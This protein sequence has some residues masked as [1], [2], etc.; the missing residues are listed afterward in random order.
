MSKEEGKDDEGKKG[1]AEKKEGGGEKKKD[2]KGNGMVTVTICAGGG[3]LKLCGYS[4]MMP[5]FLGNMVGKTADESMVSVEY[6]IAK[7]GKE[8]KKDDK[9]GG[10]KNIG[11]PEVCQTSP[12]LKD[13]DNDPAW[14]E[15][16]QITLNSSLKDAKLFLTLHHNAK[17][18]KTLM[19][20]GPL[21]L[22][23]L[24]GKD[25]GNIKKKVDITDDG[26][27]AGWVMV[28][29]TFSEKLPDL[30]GGEEDEAE[31]E[32][33]TLPPEPAEALSAG[34]QRAAQKMHMGTDKY[35]GGDWQIRVSEK[36]R[37]Y[38]DRDPYCDVDFAFEKT[39]P[40]DTFWN[41]NII[42]DAFEDT[43]FFG[44]GGR[45][46]GYAF[47]IG[48]VYKR[49][50]HDDFPV[51]APQVREGSDDD[52][53][54]D[55]SRVAERVN[56][57]FRKF[58]ILLFLPPNMTAWLQPLDWRAFKNRRRRRITAQLYAQWK[59]GVS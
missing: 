2:K 22:T 7:E 43:G 25:G 4:G 51:M 53:D 10:G 9:S 11:N 36:T 20:S 58:I 37:A 23:E 3:D 18:G 15:N 52:S 29:V 50:R 19:G 47:T 5:N 48:Q 14:N 17:T 21:D 57:T 33:P 12:Q 32:L 49:P 8:K 42:V 39:R 34:A 44:S 56:G 6:R 59:T 13:K 40:Y 26:T 24:D 31:C 38:N 55:S 41:E 28:E 1:G 30:G 46:G 16:Q 54:T 35:G 45:I 27:P